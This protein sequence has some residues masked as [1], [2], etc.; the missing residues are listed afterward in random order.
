MENSDYKNEN[1]ERKYLKYMQKKKF[2]LK[3]NN[4]LVELEKGFAKLKGKELKNGDVKIK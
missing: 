4:S 3:I 1:I 2:F